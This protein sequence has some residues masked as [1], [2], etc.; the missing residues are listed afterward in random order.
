MTNQKDELVY[1]PDDNNAQLYRT[2]NS[3]I[4][5]RYNENELRL[6][7]AHNPPGCYS[8]PVLRNWAWLEKVED[9][10]KQGLQQLKGLTHTITSEQAGILIGSGIIDSLIAL[11][12]YRWCYQEIRPEAMR[13]LSGTAVVAS[14]DQ[15]RNLV[16]AGCIPL[17]CDGLRHV[18]D[19]PVTQNL[20]KAI[21]RILETGQADAQERNAYADQIKGAGGLDHLKALQASQV[22][23]DN[24]IFQLFNPQKRSLNSLLDDQSERGQGW[25]LLYPF[26]GQKHF[27]KWSNEGAETFYKENACPLKI[28]VFISHRWEDLRN[29]DPHGDQFRSLV[30]FFSRVFMTA[31][32]WLD[33]ESYLAKEL[34]IGEDLLD[35]F[36]ESNLVTCR[37][38]S[39]SWLDL[40]SVLG[41]KELFYSRIEDIYT[42][43]KF[44][45]L[46]K[47]VQIWYDF[48]SM[49][50]SPRSAEEQAIFEHR[51]NQ[52]AHIAGQS[53]VIVLWGNE[54]LNR[55][56][57]VLEGIVARHLN[58][59][60]PAAT[61]IR[62]LRDEFF[63]HVVIP[64][65]LCR[66]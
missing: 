13:I 43:R 14:N 11:A 25:T 55:A 9:E 48:T 46:L 29:P 28:K 52:L 58:I 51:L 63:Q 49:P 3:Q 21:K 4:K 36:E 38:D 59:C 8:V 18:D 45:K 41:H 61:E 33:K 66:F 47:H 56:W 31:N 15:L 44:Y 53:E 32:G 24:A 22:L 10:R 50:Q 35:Q 64:L 27:P 40:R 65:Y 19:T 57:C 26:I 6:Q 37:C 16:E 42:R 2:I 34:S 30:E 62:S 23:H 39:D 5:P 17:L 60:A 12:S 20:I 54:S 7:K 1:P